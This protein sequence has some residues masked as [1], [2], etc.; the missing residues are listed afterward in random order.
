MSNTPQAQKKDYSYKVNGSVIEDKYHWL[1]DKNWPQ[2]KDKQIL[3]YLNQENAY[4]ENYF[5]NFQ[6]LRD[7]LF[8]ELKSRIKLDDQSVPIQKKQYSYF[9][10]NYADLDYPIYYR[11]RAG[12]EEIILDQ[13][14]LAKDQKFCSL[15]AF[16]IDHNEKFLAYSTDNSGSEYY[17]IYIKN[18]ETAE[19]IDT[20][21]SNSL[22]NIVWHKE[23]FGFFYVELNENWRPDKL[24][25]FN[26]EN[27]ET[28]LIKKIDNSLYRISI[29]KSA[30]SNYC[31]IN[32]SGHED[33]EYYL[34]NLNN[35]ELN[36]IN[37]PAKDGQHK[38]E[39]EHNNNIFYI[40][41]N[42]DRKNFDIFS[43]DLK[44]LNNIKKW[45]KLCDFESNNYLTDIAV[46]K[47]YLIIDL[48]IEGLSSVKVIDVNNNSHKNISFP[49]ASYNV[50]AY[51]TNFEQN[52]IR[53]EYS[54]LKQPKTTYKYHFEKE[55]LEILK[56]QEIP[57]KFNKD[58]YEVERIYTDCNN[59]IPVSLIYKKSLFKKDGSNPL[60]LYGYGSYGYA[61][62]A[63]FRSNIFSLLDRGFVFAI[64]HIRGGDDKGYDWYESAK[65]LTKKNTF[66]DFIDCAK[67]LIFNNYTSQQNIIIHGGSAG[68]MLIGATV[69]E[70]AGLFK[71]AIAEVPFVDVLN[72]MLDESL[73][74]TPPEFK[75]WGNPKDPEYFEYIK[76]Y[77]PYDNI[78]KQAYPHML[79]MAGLNDQRVTYWEP[80]KYVAKLREYKTD[81]H[82]LLMKMEMDSGHAGSS[83]RFDY[84]KEIADQ[85]CFILTVFDKYQ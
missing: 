69:N 67:L 19:I 62:P 58:D 56:I 68:G 74:L 81:N 50:Y 8:N 20:K 79:I 63:A 39:I 43:T 76:S 35:T 73:P 83:G 52:D 33:N 85:Y 60:Y 65:F 14:L 18:L 40:L 44:N 66:N 82:K 72:T 61:V 36:L 70:A 29:K 48:R 75:E 32:I 3:D 78:K 11:M 4:S 7:N 57:C 6:K 64:A 42:K 28:K 71:A 22:G 21:I 13:N 15:D 1:R 55:N 51:T 26:L 16:A 12:K 9:H 45:Q 27:N 80:A 24:Y 49:D 53:V 34:I 31:L 25:F 77:S 38:Y 23:I 10:R 30:D 84:L 59:K 37:G 17:H 41:S 54:S 47:N 2:I 5:Q 46:T